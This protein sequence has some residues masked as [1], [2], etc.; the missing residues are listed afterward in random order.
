M[1]RLAGIALLLGLTASTALACGTV[2]MWS[3]TYWRPAATDQNRQ[4]ALQ[5][6]TVLCG[7][8]NN[9]DA[10]RRLLA[11]LT[12]AEQRGYDRALLRHVLETHRCLPSVP[13]TEG[14]ARLVAATGARCP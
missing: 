2:Q 9:A 13:R 4:T 12:D 5:Q 14:P 11:V 1:R 3:D 6:L 8:Q 10:D 7:S